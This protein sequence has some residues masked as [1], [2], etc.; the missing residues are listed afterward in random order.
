ME[1]MIA[2]VCGNTSVWKPSEKAPMCG[3]ACQKLFL[4]VLK[5]NKVP[6]GV[7]C[8]VERRLQNW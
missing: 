5:A 2:L 6:E 4:K 3:V 1:S 8:I 7:S